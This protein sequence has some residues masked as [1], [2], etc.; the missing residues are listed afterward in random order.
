MVCFRT[1]DVLL[2]FRDVMWSIVQYSLEKQG[3]ENDN[4]GSRLMLE[5]KD[6]L[7]ETLVK[8]LD[9]SSKCIEDTKDDNDDDNNNYDNDNYDNDND[10][11]DKNR[12]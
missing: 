1:A 2:K 10:D 5:Y 6:Q 12:L 8:A 9:E 4:Y 7:L 3:I 11:D